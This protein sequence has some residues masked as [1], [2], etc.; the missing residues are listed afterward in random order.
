MLE[1]IQAVAAVLAVLA[2]VSALLFLG[3]Y[4]ILAAGG[5]G[6]R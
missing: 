6:R 4:L 3:A 2:A 5:A 1:L